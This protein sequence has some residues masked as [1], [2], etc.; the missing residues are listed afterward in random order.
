MLIVFVLIFDVLLSVYVFVYTQT[1]VEV[2]D[3][4]HY[5]CWFSFSL[6]LNDIRSFRNNLLNLVLRTAFLSSKYDNFAY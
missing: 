1:I 6:L 2:G 3:M 5:S 4:L